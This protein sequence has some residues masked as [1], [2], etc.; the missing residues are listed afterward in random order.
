VH[1]AARHLAV[2]HLSGLFVFLG[3]DMLSPFKTSTLHNLQRVGARGG[4]KNMKNVNALNG[5][6]LSDLFFEFL[7]KKGHRDSLKAMDLVARH[8]FRDA[9]ILEEEDFSEELPRLRYYRELTEESQSSTLFAMDQGQTGSI[10][11]IRFEL[12]GSKGK[13]E[14]KEP[15]R[16]LTNSTAQSLH[17]SLHRLSS[18]HLCTELIHRISVDV[19]T[20][21]V[22]EIGPQIFGLKRPDPSA[23]LQQ[24]FF[25]PCA[26]RLRP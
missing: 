9:V 4:E 12:R 14:L 26:G 10:A 19:S 18:R 11:A 17:R 22:D 24:A 8:W 6:E 16:E 23:V 2:A 1:K 25:L 13:G 21:R 7:E 20:S 15:F 3:A 5:A